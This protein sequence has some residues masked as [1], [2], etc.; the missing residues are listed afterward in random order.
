[1]IVGSVMA[2]LS[3]ELLETIASRAAEVDESNTFPH[4]DLDDLRE[5]GYLKAFVPTDFGG[6]GLSTE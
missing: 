5:A 2:F 4:E 6:H 1:M 3:N